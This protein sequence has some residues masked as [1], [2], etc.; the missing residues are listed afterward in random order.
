MQER[1]DEIIE[2]QCNIDD[3]TPESLGKTLEICLSEGALDAFFTPILM[4]KNRYGMMM[5]VLCKKEDREQM[6]RLIFQNT[7]TLGIRESIRPR[8]ILKRSESSFDLEEGLFHQKD[9]ER[10][11]TKRNKV[12]YE[13]RA[14]AARRLGISLKEVDEILSKKK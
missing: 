2:L 3:Q 5:T 11:G 6:I 4:K 14:D 10:Y 8:Y 9:S 13:D 12:E 7:T 1:R